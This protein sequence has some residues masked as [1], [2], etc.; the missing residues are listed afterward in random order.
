MQLGL[1]KSSADRDGSYYAEFSAGD[2]VRVLSEAACVYMDGDAFEALCF[3]AGNFR[4]SSTT[5]IEGFAIDRLVEELNDAAQRISHSDSAKQI[6]P[7]SASYGYTQFNSIKD[8]E[9]GRRDFSV[10]LRELGQWLQTVRARDE[11]V[12]IRGV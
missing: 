12:T 3:V 1:L 2:G 6:W 8:W 11:P 5:T 4:V 10:M 9:A 7:L